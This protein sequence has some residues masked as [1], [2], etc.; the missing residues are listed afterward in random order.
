MFLV[1]E[2]H[3]TSDEVLGYLS[4]Y[5]KDTGAILFGFSATPKEKKAN[6][7]WA[8][9]FYY[10]LEQALRDGFLSPYLIDSLDD[11]F[12]KNPA[13]YLKEKM[14]P[15]GGTLSE[16]QGVIW[17]PRKEDANRVGNALKESGGINML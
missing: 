3:K 7:F 11:E 5:A 13:K 1:D 12:E 17:L 6:F 9:T 16:W 15:E 10:S 4:D 8:A 14:H 2:F